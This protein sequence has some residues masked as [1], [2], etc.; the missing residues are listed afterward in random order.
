MN[1]RTNILARLRRWKTGAGRYVVGSFAVAYLTAGVAPCAMASRPTKDVDTVVREHVDVAH[2]RHVLHERQGV[3]HSQLDHE[4]HG[5]TTAAHETAPAPADN[6]SEHCPHCFSGTVIAHGDDRSSC[7]A[8]EDLTNAAAS[9][10]KD[11][12]QP[13]APS[14]GPAAYTLP[15]PLAA[16][17]PPPL[18]A[19]GVPPVPLNVRH[20]VFLI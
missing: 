6:R 2:D 4:A 5:G 11:A 13:F 3:V 19:V 16:A 20:C 7:F 9:H 1:R 18:R 14:F 12:P 17:R 15:P 10:A 8:L